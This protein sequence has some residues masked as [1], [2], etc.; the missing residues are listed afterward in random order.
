M[1][2]H[3]L[4]K[5]ALFL[6]G[7]KFVVL[8]Y[9]ET[10][11]WLPKCLRISFEQTTFFIINALTLDG[12]GWVHRRRVP[13][14]SDGGV[15]GWFWR[16]RQLLP[17]PSCAKFKFRQTLRRL[18]CHW[19]RRCRSRLYYEGLKPTNFFKFIENG[20]Q[21]VTL[22]MTYW[23]PHETHNSLNLGKSSIRCWTLTFKWQKYV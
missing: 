4:Q 17:H 5:L 1:G 11:L 12:W 14:K 19:R 22:S 7:R 9:N 18:G 16:W 3:I 23:W 6:D 15:F 2:Y 8:L 13:R 20:H 21:R 10:K